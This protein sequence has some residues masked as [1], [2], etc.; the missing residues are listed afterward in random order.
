[1]ADRAVFL[2]DNVRIRD[3]FRK[4]SLEEVEAELKRLIE[5]DKRQA[6]TDCD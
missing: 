6:Q 2:D 3:E 1:M 4:M 5:E